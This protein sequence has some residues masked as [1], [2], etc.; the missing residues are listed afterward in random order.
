VTPLSIHSSQTSGASTPTTQLVY[1]LNGT[2]YQSL[3][4][5]SARVYPNLVSQYANPDTHNRSICDE[6]VPRLLWYDK[7]GLTIK[8][9][10]LFCESTR[11]LDR[12][13]PYQLL[14]L[15]GCKLFFEKCNDM[16]SLMS[17][18]D[19]QRI[20]SLCVSKHSRVAADSSRLNMIFCQRTLSEY[21]CIFARIIHSAIYR[22]LPVMRVVDHALTTTLTS[23][24]ARQIKEALK[25]TSLDPILDAVC[26]LLLSMSLSEGYGIKEFLEPFAVRYASVVENDEEDLIALAEEELSAQLD[27]DGSFHEDGS[28]NQRNNFLSVEVLAEAEERLSYERQ[29]GKYNDEDDLLLTEPITQEACDDFPNS[30]GWNNSVYPGSFSGNKTFVPMSASHVAKV[31]VVLLKAMKMS[32]AMA[33]HI[34]GGLNTQAI[35]EFV[36]QSV[37]TAQYSNTGSS[38]LTP[39]SSPRSTPMRNEVRYNSP[40]LSSVSSNTDRAHIPNNPTMLRLLS[41]FGELQRRYDSH[42]NTNLSFLSKIAHDLKALS[43]KQAPSAKNQ[44]HEA[45]DPNGDEALLVQNS[46]FSWKD[47]DS[48]LQF[49]V[50]E[51]GDIL[52]DMFSVSVSEKPHRI[53]D[54]VGGLLRNDNAMFPVSISGDSYVINL[55]SGNWTELKRKAHEKFED[56]A[57]SYV[58]RLDALQDL[59]LFMIHVTSSSV[60]RVPNICLMKLCTSKAKGNTKVVLSKTGEC[61]F[62]FCGLTTKHSKTTVSVFAPFLFRLI[63]CFFEVLSSP[64]AGKILREIGG[65]MQ[66]LATNEH[67]RNIIVHLAKTKLATDFG[68]RRRLAVIRWDNVTYDDVNT[69]CVRVG[70]ATLNKKFTALFLKCFNGKK[71]SMLAMRHL[72][73]E[74]KVSF[75][76]RC[77]EKV[78]PEFDEVQRKCFE[79]YLQE[80]TKS[81]NNHNAANNLGTIGGHTSQ[82]SIGVYL[83][84]S[85][86]SNDLRP[87]LYRNSAMIS[88]LGVSLFFGYKLNRMF[89]SDHQLPVISVISGQGPSPSQTTTTTTAHSFD[90]DSNI[91]YDAE[92]VFGH[93]PLIGKSSQRILI[94]QHTCPDLF[95]I[96]SFGMP[97]LLD[98]KMHEFCQDALGLALGDSTAEFNHKQEE[99]VKQ[100][101]T[102]DRDMVIALAPGSGK[103]LSFMLPLRMIPSMLLG[104]FLLVVPSIVLRR[105]MVKLAQRIGVSCLEITDSQVVPSI[106][107]FFSNHFRLLICCPETAVSEQCFEFLKAASEFGY[108]KRIVIDECHNIC[109][110]SEFRDSY[111]KFDLFT[112]LCVPL[113]LVSGTYDDLVGSAICSKMHLNPNQSLE[114]VGTPVVLVSKVALSVI[115]LKQRECE[116]EFLELCRV[117]VL[118]DFLPKALHLISDGQGILVFVPVADVLDKWAQSAKTQFKDAVEIHTL[119]GGK[120]GNLIE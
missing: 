92:H 78:K 10:T 23:M 24:G 77:L 69:F 89:P 7:Q 96:D 6:E 108:L 115:K 15:H 99:I 47:W 9:L 95:T 67:E 101:A 68:L 103:T 12:K 34:S 2:I 18:V 19:R 54:I 25:D 32:L 109:F 81:H 42:E 52:E 100:I 83:A 50:N 117:L 87:A 48:F 82:T 53:R 28:M 13:S 36:K 120:N 112:K 75:I 94:D 63:I 30:S 88:G 91:G 85:S 60:L 84:R 49:A 16:L 90:D 3:F 35:N 37:S 55:E 22:K 1:D 93:E 51:L 70:V 74:F 61:T 113:A 106:A 40:S 43:M 57:F 110:S 102:S 56:D 58:S 26:E 107:S 71:V 72:L 62:E 29:I 4:S 31:S 79:L 21:S 98:D 80:S 64:P 76:R 59:I 20:N 66:V 73:E 45:F 116:E 111:N 11:E 104:F 39:L 14:L 119:K 38:T 44:V 105:S 86:S 17:P 97:T 8:D 65:K 33:E 118:Q 46:L 5:I 41:V 27:E 114:V